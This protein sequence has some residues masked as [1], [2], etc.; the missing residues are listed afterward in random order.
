[1]QI[2]NF[3]VKSCTGVKTDENRVFYHPSYTQKMLDT[4]GGN[5]AYSKQLTKWRLLWNTSNS[6]STQDGTNCEKRMFPAQT[7]GQKVQMEQTLT[8]TT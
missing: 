8:M 2:T 1:M 6:M 4:P 5:A 7:K 3:T